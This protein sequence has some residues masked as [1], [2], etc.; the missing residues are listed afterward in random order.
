MQENN[1]MEDQITQ[2]HKRIT[3]LEIKLLQLSDLKL[4]NSR[5]TDLKELF[6]ALAKAQAEMNTAGLSNTNPFFKSRYAD[7][8]EIVKASRPALS[9]HGLA[10]IQ[11]MLTDDNGQTILHTILT[12]S[13]GQ[14]IET[15]MRITPPKS[16]PQSLG[17]YV[18]YIRRYSYGALVNVIVCDDSDDDCETAVREE[19][20][21]TLKGTN[22][23]NYK[24]KDQ[25]YDVITK[26]QLEELNY[27]LNGYP[28]I[29]EMVLEK[30]HLQ[31]L[32]DMPKNQYSIS[33]RRI[34]EI[35]QLRESTQP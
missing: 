29:A 21:T 7:L 22:P 2:L 3:D 23:T 24:A 19:R 16:D 9:K 32:A 12:H 15:R 8:A 13:S 5:S 6:A 26:E 30:L 25:S 35:K 20:T 18:S 27:E 11:Q 1:K 31:S 34:R 10:V 14:W 28:D 17:S 4:N 33:I